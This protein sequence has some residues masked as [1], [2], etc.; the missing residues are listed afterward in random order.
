VSPT[1]HLYAAIAVLLVLALSPCSA[2]AL[3]PVRRQGWTLGLGLGVGH[4]SITPPTGPE[5][6]AKDGAVA[7]ISVA[8]ALS[9]RWRVGV[10]WHD[11]LTERGDEDLRVRR[12]MQTW[13]LAATW[14]PGNLD[15]AWSG[16]YLR[17]GAG[18]AQGRY[19]TAGADE[20]GE[21][22]DQM[23][24]DQ[25]GVA[26]HAGLGYEFAVSRE[27]AVGTL[28]SA[29][30]ASYDDELFDHGWFVPLSVSLNWSF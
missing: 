30:L 2:I 7:Q 15:N 4:G 11:W 28:L 9:P 25:T 12:S 14:V 22:I 1:R 18:I 23:A 19:L 29:N 5:F 24:T 27:V 26:F 6:Y 16:F 3:E 17:A 10:S 20:H 21:D 13:V 8:R